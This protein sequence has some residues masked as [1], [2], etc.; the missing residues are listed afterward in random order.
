[1]SSTKQNDC[2]F[3]RPWPTYVIVLILIILIP[4]FIITFPIKYLLRKTGIL[5]DR[6]YMR[7]RLSEVEYYEWLSQWEKK[8]L[9]LSYIEDRLTVGFGG[10]K[11]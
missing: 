11:F 8:H 4:F 2:D 9:I 10:I 6:T 7:N 3:I 1:M 5:R